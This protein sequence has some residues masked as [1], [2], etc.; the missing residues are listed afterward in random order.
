MV[1]IAFSFHEA[2]LRFIRLSKTQVPTMSPSRPKVLVIAGPTAVGKSATALQICQKVGG[3][4]ISADSVQVYRGLDIG[5]NKATLAERSAITHHMI[6]IADPCTDNYTAGCFFR[7]ARSV[8][9]DVSS[10]GRLPVVVG[11]TMMYVRWF[12]YGR[13]ATPSASDDAKVRVERKIKDV[14]GDWQKGVE[15]LAKKDPKRAAML[16]PNDWYRLGR[17]LEIF[18]TTGV[19]MTE[20]PLR[21]GAPG[22]ETEGEL[23]YDFRCI[24]LYDD[25]IELNRRIDRRCE[26]MIVGGVADQGVRKSILVEVSDLLKQGAIRAETVSPARAIGYRQTISYLLDRAVAVREERKEVNESVGEVEVEAFR[27]YVANFQSA[28]RGYAKQQIAWYRKDN[29]FKWIKCGEEGTVQS[30]QGLLT[31]DET[32]YE[33]YSFGT[34]ERQMA[35]REDIKQQGKQ[36]KTYVSHMEWLIEGSVE[37]NRAIALAEKCAR[38]IAEDVDVEDLRRLQEAIRRD[39]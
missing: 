30:V 31:M 28:T 12:L 1:R 15:L 29:R 10:R 6:D 17:A 2:L 18:E 4:I 16:S 37:E 39:G 36:M 35:I 22:S 27:R 9:D 33:E 13:P 14:D 7:E 38:E 24:F 23:D 19:P 34:E 11:G 20:M 8:V 26:Q 32:E 5:S 25:R 21:G 3:E